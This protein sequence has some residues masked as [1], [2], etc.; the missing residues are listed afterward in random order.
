MFAKSRTDK[1]IH[2]IQCE[3]I[4]IIAR[5]GSKNDGTPVGIK[6]LKNDKALP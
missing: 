3:I 4:S 2:L 6:K 5:N 1:E